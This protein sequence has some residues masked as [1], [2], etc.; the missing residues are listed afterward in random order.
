VDKSLIDSLYLASQKGVQIQLYVRSSCSLIPGI[1]GLSENIRVF[2]IVDRFLEHS[3][4]YY[5]QNSQQLYF[6]SADWM[7]RNFFSRLEIAFP[8]EDARIRSYIEKT[9][10]PTYLKDRVKARE[11]TRSGRW[12]RRRHLRK[13]NEDRAQMQFENLMLNA[14][15][16]TSLE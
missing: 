10:I 2:S 8:V 14:Y 11:L 5:F 3:R 15:M 7:P 1:I 16:G 6:S 12:I 9:L 13:Q 4:I